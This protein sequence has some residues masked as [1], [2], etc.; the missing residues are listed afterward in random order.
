MFGTVS[1][2]SKAMLCVVVVM[3][4]IS[5]TAEGGEVPWRLDYAAARR[6]ARQRQRPLLI[7]FGTSHCVWCKKLDDSTFRDPEIIRRLSEQFI[8]VKVDAE[9]DLELALALQI[10][11]FPT[12]LFAA[13]DGRILGRQV[14][15]MDAARLSRQLD[16][17]LKES[18]PQTEIGSPPL[19]QQPGKLPTPADE[20][21]GAE[22]RMTLPPAQP[23]TADQPPS[24]RELL[25]R[26][27][28]DFRQRQILS[29]LE[30]CATLTSTYPGS[31][32]GEEA[33]QLALQIR[34][35]SV[36]AKQLSRQLADQLAELYLARAESAVR[37]SDPAEATMFLR[38]VIQASPC[39]EQAEMARLRLDQLQN[40]QANQAVPPK[41]TI[42]AQSP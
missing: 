36:I 6:E 7:D 4:A 28:Q 1:P 31:S 29:C 19:A 8:A 37:A 40:S 39:S 21:S 30:C 11:S 16:S 38:R 34:N 17:V 10:Q 14:G 23:A 20:T 42:R 26:A 22:V 12:L 9:R 32:E 35:D 24:P 3:A 18:N 13:P 2:Q 5:A 15:Y 41:T 33:R 27:R 25:K